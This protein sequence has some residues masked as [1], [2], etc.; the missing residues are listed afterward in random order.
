MIYCLRLRNFLLEN[1]A[2][3]FALVHLAETAASSLLEAE[4]GF[5]GN[6]PLMDKS[7]RKSSE[8]GAVHLV[9]TF[10]KA[11]SQ[12]GDEKCVCYGA[13][14]EYIRPILKEQALKSLPLEHFHGNR[15]NILFHNATGT[16]FLADHAKAFLQGSA[17]NSR[18]QN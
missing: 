1:C 2:T 6:S 11:F 3:F 8:P 18:G 16:L 9:R 15:F 10:C 5:F 7:F 13:F 17:D 12:G 14:L 4:K